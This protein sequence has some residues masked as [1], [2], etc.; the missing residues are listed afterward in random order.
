MVDPQ[1]FQGTARSLTTAQEAHN[2][3]GIESP[4]SYWLQQLFCESGHRNTFEG[5]DLALTGNLHLEQSTQAERNTCLSSKKQS[6]RFGVHDSSN[7][8][9]SPSLSQWPALGGQ[10]ALRLLHPL[11]PTGTT[12]YLAGLLCWDLSPAADPLITWPRDRQE[13]CKELR[14]DLCPWRQAV[15]GAQ[16]AGPIPS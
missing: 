5:P 12:W 1:K 14:L 15:F 6:H 9:P 8:A 16:A 7:S 10:E 13:V 3:K 4:G 11:E 2:S